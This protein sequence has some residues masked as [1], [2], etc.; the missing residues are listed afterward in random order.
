MKTLVR[1]LAFAFVAA[2]A[3]AADMTDTTSERVLLLV[4]QFRAETGRGALIAESRLT[5]S[6][7]QFAQYLA[8]TGKFDHDADG[9]TPRA[10]AKQHGYEAC[11][12]GE[13]IAYEYSSRGFSAD[14]LART[15]VEG[16]TRSVTP[17]ENMELR[18][19]TETGIGVARARDGGYVAVQ[20]FAEP[21]VSGRR[22]PRR[23]S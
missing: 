18:D 12:T 19:F 7:Q 9:L 8:S 22:C 13:N 17:R 4:N 21:R 23:G 15:F 11:I 16:W 2:S 3:G 14:Q 1:L 6:A 20:V 5:S 10:R